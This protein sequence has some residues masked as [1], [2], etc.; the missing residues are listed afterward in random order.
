MIYPLSF[1]P[2]PTKTIS[3]AHICALTAFIKLNHTF[4]TEIK[5]MVVCLI[6]A[7]ITCWHYLK[8]HANRWKNEIQMK[9]PDLIFMRQ[10]GSLTKNALHG[11][12]HVFRMLITAHVMSIL[13]ILYRP[14]FCSCGCCL[15]PQHASLCRFW[16]V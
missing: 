14:L 2:T 10:N 11:A 6:T 1:C 8:F 5:S 13:R 3:E 12:L 15:V 7:C 4:I 9:K 16:L